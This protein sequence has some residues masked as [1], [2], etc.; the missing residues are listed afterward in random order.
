MSSG[1]QSASLPGTLCSLKHVV[2]QAGICVPLVGGMGMD[3]LAGAGMEELGITE[4][5]EAEMLWERDAEA[6]LVLSGSTT[7]EL[8][9][10]PAA[11]VVAGQNPFSQVLYCAVSFAA[12]L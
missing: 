9:P 3:V 10:V 7:L 6:L 1:S 5:I 8:L 11:D 12:Q 4:D 2:Q